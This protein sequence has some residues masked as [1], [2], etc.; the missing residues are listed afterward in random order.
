MFNRLSV[1][2]LIPIISL[3]LALGV[4]LYFVVL[5]TVDDFAR[6]NIEKDLGNLNRELFGVVDS[7]FMNVVKTIKADDRVSVRISQ[8]DCLDILERMT[9]AHQ[10]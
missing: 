2:I 1:K 10:F 4:S 9:F 6:N 5:R 3:M 8:V 7:A